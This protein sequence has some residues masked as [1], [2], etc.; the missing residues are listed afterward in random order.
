M[1]MRRSL[2]EFVIEGVKSTISLQQRIIDSKDFVEG[3]YN[4]HWLEKFIG[5]YPKD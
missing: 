2:E 1:R 5:K 3:K 4:I